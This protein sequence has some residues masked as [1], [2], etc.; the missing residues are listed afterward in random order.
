M[1]DTFT[2]NTDSHDWGRV[3]KKLSQKSNV[4][5]QGLNYYHCNHSKHATYYFQEEG[6]CHT[7]IQES[8]TD[9]LGVGYG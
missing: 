9:F 6:M 3:H 4:D 1:I 8:N 7:L 5:F 2:P